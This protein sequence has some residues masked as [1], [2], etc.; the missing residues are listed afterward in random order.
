MGRN[1]IRNHDRVSFLEQMK[2]NLNKKA[3][4]GQS[5]YNAKQESYLIGNGGK[6]DGIY[7]IKTMETYKSAIKEFDNWQK[8]KGY[9]F[10]DISQISRSDLK[11]YLRERQDI[12]GCSAW[13]CSRDMAAL[14]KCFN[15]NL[16]KLEV[17]LKKRQTKDIINN[18][19]LK[20]EC[21]NSTL[22]KRNQDIIYFITATGVRR[23]SLTVITPN[24]FKRDEN[25]LIYAVNVR[26]K[27]GKRRTCY[28][29]SYYQKSITDFV[30]Q[31]IADTGAYSHLWDKVNKNINTHWYR[32]EY[33]ERLYK[34]L[35]QSKLSNMPFFNGHY[36]ELI[37]QSKLEIATKKYGK[38]CK[39]YDTE[40]LAMVSQEL[41]HNRIDV[42]YTNYLG[43]FK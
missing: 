13:T 19:G 38:T 8:G 10:K 7:S 43:K 4:F 15:T 16:T 20:N 36:G 11:D 31:K 40:L 12:Q 26:E 41:G 37:N 17:G 24:N 5:K 25:G 28:V 2:R 14:N 21:R 34:E 3:C 32:A 35:E 30:N 23:Q 39:G 6:V 1:K 9:R 27:G 18:R 33:A 22:Y 42:I 29:L